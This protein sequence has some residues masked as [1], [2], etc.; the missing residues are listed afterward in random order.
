MF[1]NNRALLKQ[2]HSFLNERKPIMNATSFTTAVQTANKAVAFARASE[3]R[4][5]ERR[6]RSE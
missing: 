6:S 5:E 3:R 2:I 4:S 1:G